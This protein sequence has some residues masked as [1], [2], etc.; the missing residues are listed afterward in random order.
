MKTK[1]TLIILSTICSIAVFSNNITVTNGNDTGLGSLRA[2]IDTLNKYTGPHTITFD[3]S[4]IITLA[5]ALS[6]ISKE[7]TIDGQTNNVTIVGYSTSVNSISNSAVLRLNNLTFDKLVSSYS[8][9]TTATN[10]IYKE[11]AYSAVKV[12]AITYTANNCVFDNNTGSTVQGTAITST[13]S[14][15]II[16]LNGCKITNNISS[17]GAAIYHKGQGI[18]TLTISNCIISGNQNTSASTVYGGGIATAAPT[19]ITNCAIYNNSASRGAGIALLVGNTTTKCSLSMTDCTVSGNTA[20]TYGGGLYIQGASTDLTGLTTLTNCTFSGNSNTNA[21]NG[22]GGIGIGGG[23]SGTV[24]NCNIVVNNCTITGNTSS[25]NTSTSVGGGISKDGGT[26]VSLKVNYCIVAG[27]NSNSTVAGKDITSSAGFTSSD[28]GRNLYGGTPSWGVPV[29]VGDVAFSGDI[30]TI[31]NTTLADN[32]GKTALPDGSFVK[33]HALIEGSAA[34][35]PTAAS[36]GLQTTDQRGFV[37]DATP[38]M[39]AF[40]YGAISAVHQVVDQ[41]QLFVVKNGIQSLVDGTLEVISISGQIL[42]KVELKTNQTISVPSGL[43]IVRLRSAEGNSVQK[44]V[45]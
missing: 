42:K 7:M 25:G 34:I 37:R 43:H 9:T 35:D 6:G 29:P 38:D 36:S 5:T 13:T 23:A 26:T 4:Y 19:T 21:I 12:N 31:L 15:A 2:A 30:S 20:N 16:V 39:G 44:V 8:G 24:W 45:F 32:G 22:G 28:T 17:G 41:K 11:A 40:E 33:T 18:G 1:I 14:A 10:C 27:N 3:N